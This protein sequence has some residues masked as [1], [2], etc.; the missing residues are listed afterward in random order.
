MSIWGLDWSILV[1]SRHLWRSTL[2]TIHAIQTAHN[3]E[4]GTYLKDMREQYGLSILE[5]ARAL[6]TSGSNIELWESQGGIGP[7]RARAE[8]SVEMYLASK[9]KSDDS[10]C[11][12][13]VYPLCVAREM[14]GLSAAQIAAEYN[15]GEAAWRKFEN[16]SRL[17]PRECLRAVE[18][19]IR[20][21]FE[22]SCRHHA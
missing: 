18:L 22:Q 14:M 4:K 7:S 5:L 6:G 16:N 19:R 1:S 3:T 13:G 2:G 10:N 9:K 12:F 15:Y 8:A 17:L 20:K 11:L 21:H